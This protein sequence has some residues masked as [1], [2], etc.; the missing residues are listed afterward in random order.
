MNTKLVESLVQVI[1]SLAT[2]EYAL[3]QEE[4]II[5]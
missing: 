4:E 5:G 1:E 3:L 2:D